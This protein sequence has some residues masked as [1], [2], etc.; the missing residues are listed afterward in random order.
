MQTIII[1]L[2]ALL[3]IAV[4]GF[5]I[6]RKDKKSPEPIGQ[7]LKALLFGVLSIPLALCMARALG[8]LGAYPAEVTDVVGAIKTAF[9]AA[10]IPEEVAK[11]V[12][13]WLLLRK[14][15]YFDEKM[16]GIVYAVCVSLGFAAVENILYLFSNA[17]DFVV[18]GVSRAI[19]AVPGHFCDGILMGYYY[20]LARFYPKMQSKNRALI[21]IAPI[22]A[23]GAYDALLFVSNQAP[24]IGG[25]LTIA[26]LV[27]CV[28]LWKYCAKRIKEHL[29]RDNIY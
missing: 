27:L 4:L 23:H 2:T 21:L 14:N 26:F 18:V 10:A 15:R 20:S 11:F 25:L 24:A 22:L 7:L 12:L 3:P 1:L 19:F 28:K 29:Q 16:D 5:Y 9:F 17:E 6:Y 13:L 8:L